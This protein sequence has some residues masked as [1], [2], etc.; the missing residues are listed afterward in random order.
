MSPDLAGPYILSSDVK[1]KI[2]LMIILTFYNLK[3]INNY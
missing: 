2:S 1:M 3:L